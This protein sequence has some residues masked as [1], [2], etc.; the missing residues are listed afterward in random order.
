MHPHILII[1]CVSARIGKCRYFGVILL[2]IFAIPYVLVGENAAAIWV[3]FGRK[4]SFDIIQK[5]PS[6]GVTDEKYQKD[7][8]QEKDAAGLTNITAGEVV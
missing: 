8:S 3:I 2:S 7:K 5:D 4:V 6:M 1:I